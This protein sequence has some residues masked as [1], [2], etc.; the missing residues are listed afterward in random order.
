M[1]ATIRHKQG[2]LVVI[3]FALSFI[4]AVVTIVGKYYTN[5]LKRGLH[6]RCTL[7]VSVESLL[8]H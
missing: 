5:V 6:F 1:A 4:V 7:Q 3:D 8:H 2:Q